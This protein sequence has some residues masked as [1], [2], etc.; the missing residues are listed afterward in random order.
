VGA[1]TG[2]VAVLV[3]AAAY[4]LGVL[5]AIARAARRHRLR[6]DRRRVGAS[7]VATVGLIAAPGLVCALSGPLLGEQTGGGAGVALTL[8]L[9]GLLFAAVVTARTLAAIGQNVRARRTV[10]AGKLSDE[11]LRWMRARVA[12]AERAK[13]PVAREDIAREVVDDAACLAVA[14]H[15]DH[16]RALVDALGRA[17]ALA[18]WLA[19]ASSAVRALAFLEEGDDARARPHL[20]QLSGA[21]DPALD[22]DVAALLACVRALTEGV[23]GR[24]ARA[25]ELLP[26][27]RPRGAVP[28]A[29]ASFVRAQAAAL[30]GEPGEALRTLGRV[31]PRALRVRLLA[32]YP[33]PARELAAIE[34]PYGRR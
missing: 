27:E 5:V 34:G 33:G 18:P 11:L 29:L 25:A 32:R 16:A 24:W 17:G 26:A 15:P 14:G 23:A 2:V 9:P 1:W 3:L 28:A 6:V 4:G 21:P 30:R 7:L 31:R 10:L 8:T 19:A 12:E 20:A 22:P 13:T